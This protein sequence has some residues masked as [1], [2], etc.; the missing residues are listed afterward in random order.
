M[1]SRAETSRRA[2]LAV[3]SEMVSWFSDRPLRE[4]TS[5]SKLG[6]FECDDSSPLCAGDLSPSSQPRAC[7][8]PL[9]AA[10]LCRR[11]G[12]AEKKV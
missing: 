3:S 4:E 7:A 5:E 6:Y 11:V 12:K 9:T 1:A 2:S 8:G 10:S